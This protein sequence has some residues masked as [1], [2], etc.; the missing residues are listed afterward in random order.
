MFNHYR[1]LGLSLIPIKKG[2][3]RP[4]FLGSRFSTPEKNEA[5]EV[6][7]ERLPTEEECDQWEQRKGVG[8]GLACGPAS[9]VMGLDIDTDD[10]NILN[11]CPLSPVVK[12]GRKGETRIFGFDPRVPTCKIAGII[13]VL[14]LG[15]QTVMPP[16]IHPETN[17]PY[18]WLTD[19]TLL[20]FDVK[21]LPIFTLEMFNELKLKLE[22]Q[23]ETSSN[24]TGVE[25]AGGPWHNND[26]TRQ[27]PH[28]SH[29]R[30]KV[31]ANAMITRGVSPDEAI[32][33]LLRYDDE[34]HKPRGYFSDLTRAE[35]Q[36]DPTTNALF[37]Y[38][39][40][41]KTYNRRQMKAGEMPA[42]PLVSG[43]ELMEIDLNPVPV[44]AWKQSAWPE[45]KG[46][47]KDICDQIMEYSV[48]DQPA[49]ALG[50]ALAIAAVVISNKLKIGEVWPNIYP[51]IIA[52]TGAGKSFPY[53]TA[54]RLLNPE[55]DLD[56]LGAGGYRSSTALIKDLVGRRE[57]LDLIDECSSLFK[58]M[59]DGGIFQTD[60]IDMLNA[61]WAES[62]S[63]Y[64]GPEAAGRERL[65][66]WHP[67]ISILFSTTPDGLKGSISKDF[68][69]KGFIPR[70][71][72]FHDSEYGRLKKPNWNEEREKKIV[73]GLQ[74]F[75]GMRKD[76]KKNLIAPKPDPVDMPITKEAAQMLD[77]YSIQCS[78]RLASSEVEEIEKHFLTR[79]SQQA[80]K[81]ALIH[82]ALR[83]SQIDSSDV[84]W[85]IDVMTAIWH[86]AAP[87]LPQMGAENV[88]ETNVIRILQIIKK[89]GTIE[90]S[91]LIGKTRFLRTNERNEILQSL[92]AEGK[93]GSYLTDKRATVWKFLRA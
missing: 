89:Y 66:V 42:V 70:C 49:I 30:L 43:T 53:N 10:R 46:L 82:G 44:E 32:R 72:I 52:P 93:I 9:R 40:N 86:N 73:A 26:P 6:Y 79:A 18:V 15:R 7:C 50:G 48:R 78:E 57:R 90:Q 3:K 23:Y 92:Q 56:F 59:R 74:R 76:N 12:R 34:N 55:N 25:I 24:Q 28:G 16:T 54:K 17:Q 51:L 69:T 2:E 58:T 85:A 60:M 22:P 80:T 8:Y 83:T 37:F 33:E 27:C 65:N 35:C 4:D 45:P 41:V 63:I 88:Q 62:N 71:L 47:L 31:I 91:K 68:V 13:D 77:D 11:A 39:S 1:E 61:L 67:C 14:C 36:A 87:V 20:N 19:D 81:L 64:I 38:A 84:R 75:T 29:D 21:D 5:W